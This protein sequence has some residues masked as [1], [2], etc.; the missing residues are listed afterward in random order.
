MSDSS[1][2]NTKP[3]IMLEI[4]TPYQHF[5]EGRVESVI[6]TSLDGEL[7]VLPGHAPLVVALTPGIT[8]ITVGD[9]EK[10]IMLTEGFA[11]ISQH[12]VLVVCN[13]AEWPEEIDVKRAKD[14]YDRAYERYHNAKI[15]TEESVFSR[16]SVRRAR[17]RLHAISE[18]G[19]EKQ[20][21]ALSKLSD[22]RTQDES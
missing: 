21:R 9:S 12:L 7:G 16:H 15:N 13:A 2:D 22:K 20:K 11:E 18:H 8:K 17:E 4:V 6:L 3:K 5:Y 10:Y 19:T 14:A 1:A